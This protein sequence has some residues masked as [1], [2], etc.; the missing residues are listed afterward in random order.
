MIHSLN[1][2]GIYEWKK[3]K[4]ALGGKWHS[5]KPSTTLLN[6]NLNDSNP[7]I[8]FDKPNSSNLIDY[9]QVNFS[10]SKEWNIGKKTIIQ[11]GFSV[12]NIFNKQNII[13]QFYRINKNEN[14]I[15][16]VNIYSLKR[17]P[18]INMK[19]SF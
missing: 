15:E 9:F 4:I 3:L 1:W 6:T 19:I 13:N 11:T 14:R 17:T 10:A 5:G 7:N 2:A 18:N 12:L 8:N 16:S